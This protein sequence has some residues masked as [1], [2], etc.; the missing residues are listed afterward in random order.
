MGVHY[1]TLQGDFSI[2]DLVREAAERSIAVNYVTDTSPDLDL[3]SMSGTLL[4][5][6]VQPG[7]LIS[8]FDL[9]YTADQR[10][11]VE[12]ER[13]IGCA[14]LLDG[15]GAPLEIAG[16]APVDHEL[17]R[18]SVV[19]Y[20]EPMMCARP[21]RRG[22]RTR[23]FGI[24]IKPEFLDRFQNAVDD[25]LI[26]LRRFLKPGLH[27][28]VLP[29]SAKIVDIAEAALHEPYSGALRAL[30]RE[31]QALRFMVE[32]GS[33]LH[34]ED[35]I[36][37]TIGRRQYARV[38][39]AREVLDRSLI[40]PPKLLD[41]AR[42]LGVNVTT[43]QANFKAAFGT[44]VFGYVRR[45]RLEMARALILDHDLGVAEAG[46]RVGFNSAAAFTAAYHRY[47]G[48]PPS[49]SRSAGYGRRAALQVPPHGLPVTSNDRA[50]ETRQ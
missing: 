42:E 44:T 9:T 3:P 23:A 40:A 8:G 32:V 31:S 13:S 33:M 36:G 24:S 45:R 4:A 25:D 30:H 21:W 50:I 16:H 35:Q 47:F 41:L 22:Q 39:D 26:A 6:E 20:G 1:P 10:L 38:C 18:V 27:S 17:G 28:T 43:L 2:S 34:A 5:E 7:L 49:L 37:R 14:V 48:H 11:D 46:Y 15:W 29:R 19:G 12:V